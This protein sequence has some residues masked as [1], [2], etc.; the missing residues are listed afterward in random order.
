MTDISR[1]WGLVV[2]VLGTVQAWDSGVM[3]AGPVAQALVALAIAAPALALLTSADFTVHAASVVLMAV[4]LT[5]ARL[6][7]TVEMN[8]LH[9]MLLPVA[10]LLL[11]R[12]RRGGHETRHDAHHV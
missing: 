4:C 2:L 5:V 9:L 12:A 6:L 7:A 10:A 3:A 1:F 8:G 11:V